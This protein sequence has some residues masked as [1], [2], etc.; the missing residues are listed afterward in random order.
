M[1]GPLLSGRNPPPFQE[2]TRENTWP[3]FA[4]SWSCVSHGTAKVACMSLGV[5]KKYWPLG[6]DFSVDSSG[7][8]EK[9]RNPH[10]TSEAF[11]GVP[12]SQAARNFPQHRHFPFRALYE[13]LPWLPKGKYHCVLARARRHHPEPPSCKILLAMPNFRKWLKGQP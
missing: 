8:S 7:L 4:T 13:P 1:G 3:R 9:Q 5:E 10:W 12:C 2:F 6:G 11:V